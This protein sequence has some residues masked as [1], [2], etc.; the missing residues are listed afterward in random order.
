MQPA[1]RE[2]RKGDLPERFAFLYAELH[3]LQGCVDQNKNKT[4]EDLQGKKRKVLSSLKDSAD[5]A[6]SMNKQ[7]GR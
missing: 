7:I 2:G 6:D 3:P 5:V 1:V 4:D